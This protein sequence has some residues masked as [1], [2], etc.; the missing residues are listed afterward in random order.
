LFPLYEIERC[1]R[2]R[3][4]LN[5]FTGVI[6]LSALFIVFLLI[7]FE[8]NTSNLSILFYI[9]D[10]LIILFVGQEVFRWFLVP[11]LKKHLRE[12]LYE[13]ILLV[14][15]VFNL[16]LPSS[17]YSFLDFLFI[18]ISAK[19]IT[20]LYLVVLSLIMFLHN[21]LK[22]LRKN[23]LISKIKLHPGSLFA[24]SFFFLIAIGTLLLSLPK[25]TLPGQEL[26]F[27]DALFTSTS[28]V[29][30][31]GLSTIIVP[32]TLST[33]G[34]GVLFLLIQV[35]GLGVMTLT[36]FFAA[37][38][39]GGLSFRF[40]VLM[41]DMLSQDNISQVWTILSKIILF[42]AIFEIGGSIFLYLSLGGSFFAFDRTL[43]YDCFFHSVSAFCNAGFSL[44]SEGFMQ[45]DVSNN[46]TYLST[47]M[48]LI[49]AGGL[50]FG[51]F[52]NLIAKRPWQSK[53]KRNTLRLT[54]QSKLVLYTTIVLIIAGTML[55]YFSDTNNTL[56]GLSEFEKLFHSL[57]WSVTSRT[58][59]F[60][61]TDTAGLAPA[62]M[63]LMIILMWIGASPGSTG[64]GIKTTTIGITFL[65][66]INQI[67][68][69][70][71]IRLFNRELAP[72]S[73]KRAF[74]VVISSLLALGIGSTALVWVEPGKDAMDLIFETTSAL[75]TV[76][77]S[78]G[79]TAD[80]S[81]AG[82][83]III[84]LMFIGR[85]GVLAFLLSFHNPGMPPKYNLPT[86][87]IIVG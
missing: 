23:H 29:C 57:F 7:G 8:I 17:I 26:S 84:F 67:R 47:I 59:G 77:L 31:T 21:I 34:K 25:A 38:F 64:G 62:T 39:A 51:L 82:K 43:F 54:M 81:V 85:I 68:G 2:F 48:V 30:V 78:R 37:L 11:N 20:I 75:G 36:T 16:L 86:E 70:E 76:G 69:N 35:G 18:N 74:L 87:N 42:T 6:S 40:R 28:A 58:A 73:V 80:L 65:A 10:F 44:Y 27:T 49:V 71:K 32:E 1:D 63:M 13:N 4:V 83:Y 66:L 79:I 22:L 45:A 61:A 41:R 55:I 15:I 14:V 24:L 9:L 3:T 50:G 12:R 56:A 46:Y 52:A 60:N 19:N 5:A 53:I 72:E 33:F